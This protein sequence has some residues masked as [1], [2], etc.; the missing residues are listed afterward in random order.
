VVEVKGGEDD[1]FQCKCGKCFRLPNSLPRDA[2]CCRGDVTRSEEAEAEGMQ[3]SEENYEAGFLSA[4]ER[5]PSPHNL[6]NM[7]NKMLSAP[8][9]PVRADNYCC[10]T[11]WKEHQ[12]KYRD[13]EVKPGDH[14]SV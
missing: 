1:G 4:T 5:R 10:D 13:W 11:G 14:R 9:S 7:S 3:L 12:S 2:K 6:P 8:T